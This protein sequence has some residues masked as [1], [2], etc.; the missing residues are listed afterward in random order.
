[1][2]LIVNPTATTMSARLKNL[3]IY[4]L[5]GRY[6]VEVAETEAPNH[7]IDITRD[8]RNHGHDLVVPFGGDG[9]VNEAAN[10]LAGTDVPLSPLPG[11]CTNVV[12][13]MLGV[14]NDVVDATERLL[15]L[16]DE[17]VPRRIDLGSAN[18]RKFIFSSGVGM[19]ADVTRWVDDRPR[20]K[21]KAGLATFTFAALN[22]Y[23]RDYR[24]RAAS[25]V[26]EADGHRYQGLSAV[27]QNSDPYTYFKSKPLRACEDIA[28]DNGYLSAMVMQRA[29]IRDAPGV[30]TR[31]FSGDGVIATHPQATSLT[32]ISEITAIPAQPGAKLPVE[33]DGD[34]IGLH[35]KV[36]YRA[37]PG[38]LLVL[39]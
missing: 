26:V 13:R 5:R 7:A 32:R 1:M 36:E 28:I 14:P 19:D 8:A 15:R 22:T 12:C 2:L 24:G 34:Y 9:T 27:V 25:L 3:V 31:M 20:A 21:S 38:D 16:A 30:I 10:G 4:A 17:F 33:V 39:A 6:N 11:G 23:V 18:G 29:K 37:H 35:A